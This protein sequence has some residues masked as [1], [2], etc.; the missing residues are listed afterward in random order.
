[1]LSNPRGLRAMS[2]ILTMKAWTERLKSL[3]EIPEVFKDHFYQRTESFPYTVYIPANSTLLKK[4]TEKILSL[5]DDSLTIL[6][7]TENGVVEL[8]CSFAKISYIEKASMLMLGTVKIFGETPVTLYFNAMGDK[9]F[10][11]II[12]AI[13]NN[14]CNNKKNVQ[15]NYG[16]KDLFEFLVKSNL[17][18]LNSVLEMIQSKEN[19][20]SVVFQ[21]GIRRNVKQ[22]RSEKVKLEYL[23]SHVTILTST[24]IIH[25]REVKS[26]SLTFKPSY[27]TVSLIIPLDKVKNVKVRTDE[28][29]IKRLIVDVEGTHNLEFQYEIG[30]AKVDDFVAIYSNLDKKIIL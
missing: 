7:N 30:N 23:A 10:S 6:E 4:R 18:Y 27:G 17:K 3:A 15:R 1:M 5:Y 16:E 19:V 20:Y 29:E 8:K 24:E 26:K 28:E 12:T 9:I 22:K 14:L 11:R 21:P 25:V 13:R 2:S